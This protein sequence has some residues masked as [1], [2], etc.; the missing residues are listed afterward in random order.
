MNQCTSKELEARDAPIAIR[1]ETL[2][3]V[4]GGRAAEPLL[5][6]ALCLVAADEGGYLLKDIGED[7]HLREGGG[8]RKGE[9]GRGGGAWDVCGVRVVRGR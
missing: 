1:V 8:G 3:R 4:D 7:C 5:P 2:E 6:R 9:R